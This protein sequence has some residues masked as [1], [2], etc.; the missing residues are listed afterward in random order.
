MEQY[1]KEAGQADESDP[2]LPGARKQLEDLRSQH[3]SL[4]PPVAAHKASLAKL[5]KCR[6]QKDRFEKELQD[7]EKK[8]GQLQLDIVGKQSAIHATLGHFLR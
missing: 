8:L 4:R 2:A 7:Q 6:A 1:I 5:E 3:R